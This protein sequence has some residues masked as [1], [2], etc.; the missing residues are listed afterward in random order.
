MDPNTVA[1]GDFNTTLLPIDRS[2]RQK[3]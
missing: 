1:V 3:K 2:S